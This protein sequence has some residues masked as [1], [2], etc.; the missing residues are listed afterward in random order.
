LWKTLDRVE[1]ATVD[2]GDWRNNTRLHGEI[3]HV[4]PVEYQAA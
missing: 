4:P 3:S 1:I 2:W